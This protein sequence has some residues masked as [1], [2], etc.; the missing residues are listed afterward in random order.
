[1]YF[2]RH[3]IAEFVAVRYLGGGNLIKK[4]GLKSR[5]K[6]C[7]L[8]LNSPI[9][10]VAFLHFDYTESPVYWRLFF[11]SAKNKNVLLFYVMTKA[12][13]KILEKRKK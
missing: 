4:S 6:E 9:Y 7:K 10:K 1:M 3:I 11:W 13:R 8:L 12:M 5:L 2:T